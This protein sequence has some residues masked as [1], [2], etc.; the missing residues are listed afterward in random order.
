VDNLHLEPD[1]IKENVT[2]MLGEAFRSRSAHEDESV[3]MKKGFPEVKNKHRF[4][5]D[6]DEILD[7]DEIMNK[8]AVVRDGKKKKRLERLFRDRKRR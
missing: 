5:A 7:V 3:W 8:K 6:G 2:D 4:M 1:Q